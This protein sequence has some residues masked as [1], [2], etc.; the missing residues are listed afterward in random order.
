MVAWRGA[1]IRRS[2]NNDHPYCLNQPHP[3]AGANELLIRTG[4]QVQSPFDSSGFQFSCTVYCW[5]L[6]IASAN[7]LFGAINYHS[8][9]A[10]WLLHNKAITLA[11]QKSDAHPLLLK[12]QKQRHRPGNQSSEGA[13]SPSTRKRVNRSVVNHYTDLRGKILS[14][15]KGESRS[16]S[17][18]EETPRWWVGMKG[19]KGKW[20]L[21]FGG[22]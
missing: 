20:V 15:V 12:T 16:V 4:M 7:H 8:V 1:L 18:T 5:L 3:C 17:D 22:I 10:R 11:L 19:R 14:K 2:S 13:F 6:I 21:T 9:C